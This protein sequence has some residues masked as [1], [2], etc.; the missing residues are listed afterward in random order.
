MSHDPPAKV[1][2]IETLGATAFRRVLDESTVRHRLL[3]L[4]QHVRLQTLKVQPQKLHV[5][6]LISIPNLL[7]ILYF[8]TYDISCL[9]QL[10]IQTLWPTVVI[11]FAN[12]ACTHHW[13]NVYK[14]L[15]L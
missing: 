7:Y 5:Y 12:C 14:Q 4:T 11:L 15:L 1:L 2:I 13:M 3:K 10:L 8:I 6:L 9:D